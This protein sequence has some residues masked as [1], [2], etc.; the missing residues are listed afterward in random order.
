MKRSDALRAAQLTMLEDP[1]TADPFF[2]ASF[3]VSGE[4]GPIDLT[5]WSAT[6]GGAR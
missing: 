1:Q 6:A 3:L 4:N 2:W 5:A